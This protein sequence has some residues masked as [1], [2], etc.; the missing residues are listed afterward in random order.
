M[1]DCFSGSCPARTAHGAAPRRRDADRWAVRRVLM[2][3]S[4]LSSTRPVADGVTVRLEQRRSRSRRGKQTTRTDRLAYRV[5]VLQSFRRKMRCCCKNPQH[6]CE[7]LVNFGHTAVTRDSVST[8]FFANGVYTHSFYSIRP[9]MVNA[10]NLAY[11][12]L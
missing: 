7:V 10:V 12:Q 5:V 8:M 3:S 4:I 9:L 11:K 1:P 2:P 6:V